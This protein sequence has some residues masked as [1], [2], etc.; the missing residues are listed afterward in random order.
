MAVIGRANELR[1]VESFL[2]DADPGMRVL[3]LH[4]EAGI[5]KTTIWHAA[6]DAAATRGYRVVVTRP[7]AAEARLPFAGLNDLFADLADTAAPELPPP[8]RAALDLALMRAGVG[9]EPMQPLALSLAVLEVLRGAA[10]HQPI[11]LA[12]DDVQWLDES[13]AGVVRFA[14]RRL[15]RAPAVVIAT[16]RTEAPAPAGDAPALADLPAERITRVEIRALGI[17]AIDRLVDEAL[18]LQLAPTMLRRVHAMSG[19]NPFYAMEIGRALQ[20][21]G[22]DRAT[23]EVPLPESLAG[24]LRDR[25]D[26]L[27]P[28]AREVV[29]HASALSQPTTALL[30]ATL[31]LERTRSGLAAARDAAVLATG[32]GPIR[33]AHPLLATEAYAAL[34]EA[35]RSEVHRHLARVVSEPE[36][37]AR[38]LALASASPD[39]EVADALDMAATH[40][41]ARGA[42]D[43]AAELSELAAARTPD[44]DPARAHRLAAAGRYRLMAGDVG[45]ARRI[46]ERALDEPDAKGGVARGELLFQLAGVRQLMDDF[47]A[48][49]ALGLEALPHAAGN[50]TLTVQVKHLLSGVAYVTGRKFAA[51]AQHAFDAMRLA[52]QSDDPRLVAAIIGSYASWRYATGHGWELELEQRAKKLE[53][54]MSSFRT[55]DLP[56]FDFA[57]IEYWEGETVSSSAR[58]RALEERAERDGDYSSLPFLLAMNA[59][60]D[61]LDGRS[62]LARGRIERARRLSLTT[63]QRTAL[64]HTL[65][66]ETRLE[67]RLGDADRALGAARQAFALMAAT[68]WSIGEW[69]MRSDLALLELSRNRP[70][71][72]YEHIAEVIG[73]SEDDEAGRRRW[74]HAVAVEVLV[75]LGRHD[76]AALLLGALEADARQRDSPRLSANALRARARLL[77]ATG[78]LD[79]AD[80]AIRELMTVSRTMED[81][82]ELARTLFVAGEIH[83]RARRRAKARSAFTEALETF[84]FIGARLWAD[85]AREQLGRIGAARAEGG[86]TPTQQEVAEL[87]AGGLTNRQVAERLFMSPHTVEAHLSVIYRA[88]GIRS[89]VE[90]DTALR[91]FAEVRDSAA[92]IRDSEGTAPAE[93]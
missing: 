66:E 74:A 47:E 67:A 80:A 14:L 63:D 15:D 24:L 16:Q 32:D 60:S 58:I 20:A 2:D 48:A 55:L 45:H 90:L 62:D 50:V 30:G 92:V 49:E 83:R 19:G 70:D 6:L 33:F 17:E 40:A 26:T 81:P 93:N 79:A 27:A 5:G 39:A 77:A 37:L 43:A 1:L 57:N 11:A 9:T 76:D 78:D 31:G 3:L 22:L 52:E 56:A 13:S 28:D 64:L 51:G 23:G 54:W 68:R 18:G 84:E 75:A 12:I 69:L 25:L 73:P 71:A 89:R 82:W 10:S 42:P 41:H 7:T 85:Q 87:V 53:P 34:D 4:G 35:S 29:N 88:L 46:L 59:Q 8:Q 61:I 91:T 36:E 65:V 38:H 72:A 86:L 44:T 21:R